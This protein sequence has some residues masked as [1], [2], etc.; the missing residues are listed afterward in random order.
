MAKNPLIT[1]KV[2]QYQNKRGVRYAT[3]DSGIYKFLKVLYTLTFAWNFV[4]N[5]FY[6]LVILVS[7]ESG[8]FDFGKSQ[9]FF[10]TVCISTVLL[11]AGYVLTIIKKTR[12]LGIIVS[13]IPIAAAAAA[14]GLAVAGSETNSG[15]EVTKFLE[16]PIYYYWRH[17]AP[18]AIGAVILVF[19]VL[20]DISAVINYNKL[21]KR[22]EEEL[23]RQ[24]K[25]KTDNP[26]DENWQNFLMESIENNTEMQG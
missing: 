23:Y 1:A 22:I 13:V 9:P 8:G 10:I 21:Y 24:F 16:L 11:I 5:V 18:A 26:S 3:C 7:R 15:I 20:T 4:F 12:I 6:I 19:M 2:R 14:I 25:S 17:L